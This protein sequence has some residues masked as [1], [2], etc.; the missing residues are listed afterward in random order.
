LEFGKWSGFLDTLKWGTLITKV[1]ANDIYI[2]RDLINPLVFTD[3]VVWITPLGLHQ[4]AWSLRHVGCLPFTI[5][6]SN[7]GHNR[8]RTTLWRRPTIMS[9]ICCQNWTL[10]TRMGCLQR[11]GGG[12]IKTCNP[13][14]VGSVDRSL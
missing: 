4:A 5:M 9:S 7:V 12:R 14:V 3:L 13:Y 1:H 2:K 10:C 6:L 8:S 11:W